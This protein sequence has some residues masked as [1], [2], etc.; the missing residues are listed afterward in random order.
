MK[1]IYL[2]IL[3]LALF[4]V[5]S[6]FAQNTKNTKNRAII[7]IIKV[8]YGGFK[9]DEATDLQIYVKIT[10][11][12]SNDDDWQLK[13]ETEGD[14]WT[15]DYSSF[16]S[17]DTVGTSED[18][19]YLIKHNNSL[20][21]LTPTES[22]FMENLK[23]I[24]IENDGG[25]PF[26]DEDTYEM[27]VDIDKSFDLLT[28]DEQMYL[29][30]KFLPIMM[31]D[32][33]GF[34]LVHGSIPE[35]YFI[36]KEVDILLNNSEIWNRVGVNEYVAPST[37]ENLPKYCEATNYIK[38]FIDDKSDDEI[39]NWY[40][41][42]E[43][44]YNTQ[45]YASFFEEEDK[46]ILTYWFYYLYNSNKDFDPTFSNH[47]ISDWEGMN[48]VF[49]KYNISQDYQSAIPIGAATSAHISSSKGQRKSWR[50][51]FKIAGHSVVFVSNGSHATYFT[52]DYNFPSD[53]HY[54]N[55]K[56]LVPN[57]IDHQ[58]VQQFPTYNNNEIIEYGNIDPDRQV[59]ILT[60]IDTV[61]TSNLINYW[62][63]FG[64]RWGQ[65][66]GLIKENNK[67]RFETKSPSGPPFIESEHNGNTDGYKWFHP[68]IWYT[69]QGGDF[70]P[71]DVA[72]VLDRSGSMSDNKI[73]QAKNA[74]SQFLQLLRIED[75]GIDGDEVAVCS[76]S[77]SASTNFSMT[78]ITSQQTIDDAVIAI[79][80]I[81]AGGMTS[82]GAGMQEGQGQLVAASYKNYPQGM[83]LL[84]D[85][86]ENT[87]PTVADI[88]PT[89]PAETYIY[90]IGFG[91]GC[92]EDLM[93]NIAT[94]TSGFYRFV[95]NDGSNISLICN[96][97][98]S[99]LS[100]EQLL[101]GYSGLIGG[102]GKEV[103]E[104]IVIIDD[105]CSQATFNLLWEHTDSDL[106]LVL[107]DPNNTVIDSLYAPTNDSIHFS[108][109]ST[110]EFYRIDEPVSGDWTLRII[111]LTVPY[112]T[113][114]YDA[115]VAG[116]S[117]IEMQV[118]FDQDSYVTG[119]PI[120]ITSELTVNGI[121]ITNAIVT[122][123][124]EN[125]NYVTET[126]DLFDDGNHDDGAANDGV[127]GNAYPNANTGGSYTFTVS[128]SGTAPVGGDFTRI[129]SRSTYV[130]GPIVYAT[131]IDAGFNMLAVPG[132]PTP[133]DPISIFGDDID[134]FYM[135]TNNS[136]IWWW[137]EINSSYWIPDEI[138]NGYG[139][140]VKA[141]EDN[142]TI[143]ANVSPVT[144][145]VTI[146]LT[147]SANYY[148]MQHGYHM[149]GNPFN[150]PINF[151]PD[152]FS[153]DSLIVQ[154]T[155]I[156]ENDCY[157]VYPYT[158][159]K[160][161]DPWK[162]FWIQTSQDNQNITMNLS[163]KEEII[164]TGD[165]DN[166]NDLKEIQNWEIQLEVSISDLI[167]ISNYAGVNENASDGWDIM[168]AIEFPSPNQNYISLFFPHDDWNQYSADYTR[169]VRNSA[170]ENPQWNIVVNSTESGEA[171]L[172]WNIPD[173]VPDDY[174]LQLVDL[175]NNITINIENVTEYVFDIIAQTE[176]E[177]V[178]TVAPFGV[179]PEP[180]IP[181][182]FGLSA[183]FPN[184]FTQSTEIQYQLP[185][186]SQVDISIYNVR[187]QMVK[188][189]ES[190]QVEPGY[191][192][193]SWN[194]LDEYGKKV[195]PG[196]YFY[197]IHAKGSSQEYKH[198]NKMLLIR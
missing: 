129:A 168:D 151:G 16:V 5:T 159:I 39:I 177:F 52:S 25:W 79:S 148:V 35:E 181:T 34:S 160:T 152:N 147:N 68:Y 156:W 102:G 30:E 43:D 188:V 196:I 50:S 37:K 73:Y 154:N 10:S 87:S 182:T 72:L 191:Y 108:S 138:E 62:H 45:L 193:I 21:N 195:S 197:T 133:P 2:I 13:I 54:G 136:N 120:V 116:F 15:N 142:T 124:I 137:S 67:E 183:N 48:I 121:P 95:Y 29:A 99:A 128:A 172:T 143:D 176:Y 65:S 123:E 141:W 49:D 105:L 164:P 131:T 115:T 140:W 161:I 101:A 179:G 125:P 157:V 7:K 32:D 198:C 150:S 180:D 11:L 119:Q 27:K 70:S 93:R 23:L 146:N 64:G 166:L 186:R 51:I 22:C 112:G 9:K 4:S 135:S 94:T 190:D 56:W 28:H 89:I 57:N 18:N 58:I 192:K 61:D 66:W 69:Q 109:F 169:D 81:S 41:L 76:Y 132:I 171:K 104:H 80:G 145:P 113:E 88:L 31:F 144:M 42:Y 83:L 60:R 149:L 17:V 90:T 139:Y 59:E 46:V 3:V 163:T 47:H 103:I 82:I 185:E 26:D 122:A 53:F 85:G 184:P 134:P 36:P 14:N 77:S 170:L 106:D 178:F 1:K 111:G 174:T 117:G 126:I 114:N 71:I 167:D 96:E 40:Q 74:A 97:I 8:I 78:E 33:G 118:A 55:G 12:Q 107:I 189:L 187:G 162:A 194:G 20:I 92:D 24:F 165:K 130:T 173:E 44:N 75:E 63:I 98:L 155:W 19:I 158:G 127:Y 100:G 38:F 86:W 110:Q 175:E 153:L 84:S 91:D 6:L